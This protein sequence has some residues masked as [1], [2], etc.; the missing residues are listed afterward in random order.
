MRS[1]VSRLD[2]R[3]D[4]K[5][6]VQ[7]VEQVFELKEL[8]FILANACAMHVAQEQFPLPEHPIDSG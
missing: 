8:A 7:C 5:H 6:T 3:H 4:G 2:V 1:S